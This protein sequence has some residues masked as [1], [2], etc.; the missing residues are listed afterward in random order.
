MK[1]LSAAILLLLAAWAG[2][3]NAQQVKNLDESAIIIPYRVEINNL[4]TT[5]ILFPATIKSVD[6]GSRNILAEKVGDAENA[7]K[8]KADRLDQPE[9]NLSVITADGKLY[10]FIVDCTERPAYQAVDL[11]KQQN[12]EQSEINF[13]NRQ[14]NLPL[15]K[16]KCDEVLSRKHFMNEKV[17]AQKME[18]KIEGIYLDQGNM[19]FGMSVTNHSHIDYPVEFC[20]FFTRDRKKVKRM[21]LQEQEEKP[22]YASCDF[23]RIIPG[24]STRHLVFAF[25]QFT[26]SDS[27]L[28][29]ID[30][31]EKNGDRKLSL[32]I[33]GKQLLKAR[34]L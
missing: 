30:L 26:I 21:A 13:T 4:K 10:S 22:L 5:V 12:H 11:R 7:L 15:I 9:S 3:A 27:K 2:V 8:I 33:D 29:V 28:L 31:Y 6:R 1:N 16:A 18:L 32:A 34:A 23:T 17:R 25:P 20:S 14:L 19:Y 24:K